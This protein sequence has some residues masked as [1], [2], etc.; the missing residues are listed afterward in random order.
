MKITVFVVQ[1]VL[2]TLL[3]SSLL[4][5][6]KN[7]Q[8]TALKVQNLE[9]KPMVST[10][11]SG[12]V[13]FVAKAD[14]AA[15]YDFEFNDGS[16]V[17]S[18]NTG[19]IVHTFSIPGNN[20]YTVTVTAYDVAGNSLSKFINIAVSASSSTPLPYWFD[21]F[22]VDGAPD[23]GKWGY[24]LTNGING[25]GGGQL[26]YHTN[27]P[28]NVIVSK[29]SLKLKS[30]RENYNGFNFTSAR[31]NTKNKFAFT[32]GKVEIRAKLPAGKGTWPA[33]WLL[34]SNFDTVSWPECG[35]IDILEQNADKDKVH[36][37]LHYPARFGGNADGKTTP[38][39]NPSSEYH[40][41]SVDWTPTYINIYLDNKLYHSVPNSGSIPFNHD[42]YM[43]LDLGMGGGFAGPIDPAFAAATMEIDYVRVYK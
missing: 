25:W 7:K 37:T 43:I 3:F 9:F 30:L 11:G 31:I 15:N 23:V 18:N 42:F 27:R 6:K 38:I 13:T 24:D 4:S 32:Y 8:E 35:E 26:Q 5:C 29:G 22:N 34:G 17:Q 36:G 1:V 14:H 19:T 12:N 28:E 33:L 39:T 2:A 20:L 21:E 16:A 41:Y 10:D 40:I